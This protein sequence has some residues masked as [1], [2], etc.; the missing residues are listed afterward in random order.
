MRT[1]EANDAV[2]IDCIE[3]ARAEMLRRRF[4]YGST[5]EDECKFIQKEGNL[6]YMCAMDLYNKTGSEGQLSHSENGINR[7]YE[8][9]W[10]SESLLSGIVPMVKTL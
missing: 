1:G 9:S 10:I 4:P 8:S 5:E 2:L 7:T 6:L 3:C